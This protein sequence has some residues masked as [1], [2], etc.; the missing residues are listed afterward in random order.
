MG[1]QIDSKI[2]DIVT[3]L[4]LLGLLL[5]AAEEYASKSVFIFPSAVH[6]GAFPSQGFVLWSALE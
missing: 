6:Y 3:L 1:R 2:A 5:S 4:G